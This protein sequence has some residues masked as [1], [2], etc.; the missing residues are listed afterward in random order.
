MYEKHEKCKNAEETAT[1]CAEKHQKHMSMQEETLM[2][3]APEG[4]METLRR[5][6]QN[7]VDQ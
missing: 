7:K 3:P 6:R 1:R 2:G 4:V 5:L